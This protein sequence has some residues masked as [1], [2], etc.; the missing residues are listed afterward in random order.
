[1]CKF[2]NQFKYFLDTP[3]SV[4]GTEDQVS[5]DG[6]QNARVDIAMVI[7]GSGSIRDSMSQDIPGVNNWD[8]LKIFLQQVR[9]DKNTHLLRNNMSTSKMNAAQRDSLKYLLFHY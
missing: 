9:F 2:A 4:P 7:D 8:L 5:T 6:C 3:T 1:M